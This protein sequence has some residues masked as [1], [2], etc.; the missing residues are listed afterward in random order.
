MRIRNCELDRD[1]PIDVTT[2][3]GCG[4]KVSNEIK[5]GRKQAHTFRAM[6]DAKILS[7]Q[8]KLNLVGDHEGT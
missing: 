7:Y 3:T 8:P 2:L 6:Y 5:G 1:L 4:Y